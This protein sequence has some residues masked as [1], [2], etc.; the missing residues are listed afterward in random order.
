MSRKAKERKLGM[1]N[2][3]VQRRKEVKEE[4]GVKKKGGRI[5]KI[6]GE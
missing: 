5:R 3:G 1:K 2:K 4:E 6:M